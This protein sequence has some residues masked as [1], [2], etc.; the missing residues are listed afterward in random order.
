M[1]M[2][3]AA[4]RTWQTAVIRTRSYE[5]ESIPTLT[6][7]SRWS[8]KPNRSPSLKGLLHRPRAGL[9]SQRLQAPTEALMSSSLQGHLGHHHSGCLMLP[10]SVRAALPVPRLP[11]MPQNSLQDIHASL[12]CGMRVLLMV[13][14]RH[15]PGSEADDVE[16]A[17][18]LPRSDNA[19]TGANAG[20]LESA[21]QK[22]EALAE[23]LELQLEDAREQES[24][25]PGVGPPLHGRLLASDLPDCCM[26]SHRATLTSPGAPQDPEVE[27]EVVS[28][29]AE[30]EK[31]QQALASLNLQRG[32]RLQ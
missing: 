27:A 9:P 22:V 4:I 19:A 3:F 2:R 26:G 24:L 32:S 7:A 11:S 12:W 23:S 14:L 18:Y 6:V 20:R 17:E 28:I 25:M 29:A 13:A 1:Q 10:S 21:I 5:S 16:N 8:P 15:I 31:A 30:L